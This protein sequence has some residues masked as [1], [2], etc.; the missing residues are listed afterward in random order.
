MASETNKPGLF[1][2]VYVDY[3]ETCDGFGGV[4]C[5]RGT[6]EAAAEEMLADYRCREAANRGYF[7]AKYTS[8]TAEIWYDEGQSSGC[9]WKVVEL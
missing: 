3:G 1:A 2:V 6:F 5:T 9:T 7:R 8:K 4:L